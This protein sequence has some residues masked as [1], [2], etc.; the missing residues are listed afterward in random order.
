MRYTLKDFQAQYPTDEACLDKVMEMKFGGTE[1][2]CPGCGVAAAK[3]HRLTNRRAYSCQECGHHIYPCAATI[4][5]KSRTDLTKWFYAMYLFTATRHGVPAKE[6]ERQ[7]GVTYKCAWRMAHELRK[8]MASADHKGPLGGHVEIDETFVGGH[9]SR[10]VRRTKGDNKTMV[11]GI[12]ERDGSVRAG[13]ILDATARVLEATVALNVARGSTISTDEWR[14]YNRLT[15]MSY[16]HGTVNHSAKEYVRGIHHTNTLEGHWSLLKR[17]IKGT[18][19][20]VSAKHLWKYVNE[21]SYRRNM[22]HSQ[23]AMFDRLVSALSL[24]R[25]ADD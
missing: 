17:A 7:L 18:H 14:G 22:R 21:F 25:L 24:P 15:E 10:H 13:P 6:L 2:T 4:F 1:L 20:H 19:V 9:Q 23:A 5:E 12:V 3:F 8:L 16:T 11:M